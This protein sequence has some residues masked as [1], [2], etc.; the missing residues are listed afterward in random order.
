M[1]SGHAAP[2]EKLELLPRQKTVRVRGIQRHEHGIDKTV[3]GDRA[4]LN[5]QGIEKETVTR[6]NVLATPG[7]YR[8][9]EVFN[10]T[11]F[12]LRTAGRPLRHMTRVRLHIGT[13]EVMARVALLETR[14]LPPGGEGLVQFRTEGPVVCDW[15]DHYVVRSYSPQHTIGGGV[16]LEPNARKERR[17]DDAVLAR[18]K[19]M[20]EGDTATVVEQALVRN[21]FEAV[22]SEELARELAIT[23][24]DIT[25]YIDA[26]SADGKVS[27]FVF[28][29]KDYVVHSR[30]MAE[31]RNALLAA[32]D[33][34]HRQ[35]PF[36]VGLKRPELR[37]K[38]SRGFSVPL[39][40]AIVSALLAEGVLEEDGGR[41]RKAGH[42][43]RLRPEEQEL[44]DRVA[45]LMLEGGFSP[46][47]MDEAL[48]GAKKVLADRVRTALLE[49]GVL[50]DVGES[51]VFHRDVVA[52][53][54][55]IIVGLFKETD[56]LAASDVRKRMDTTRRYAIP[57]LNYFD[58]TGLTQRRGDKRVL[59]KAAGKASAAVD[60]AP[61]G[62][63]KE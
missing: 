53:G 36:R 54:R 4:A 38:S 13:A 6:G 32:L 24:E 59:R 33:E 29:G 50:V 19:A 15:N 48:A 35:N 9:T 63:D 20:R 40:D 14:E 57:L 45:A 17:F 51:V 52:R 28:E 12:L 46:P 2:G 18:L 10:A 1:L 60:N 26:L 58:S 3:L 34:F 22:Q 61:T 27:R 56:E 25:R 16:V 42:E 30:N 39:F 31:G 41:V 21:R 23:G 11:L 44:S 55:D 8:P 43:V 37:D 47:S 7:Y 62:S 5:L 49:T